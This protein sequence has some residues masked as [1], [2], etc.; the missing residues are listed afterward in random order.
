MTSPSIITHNADSRGA[1]NSHQDHLSPRSLISSGLWEHTLGACAGRGAYAGKDD[2]V[3]VRGI[4]LAE[5]DEDKRECVGQAPWFWGRWG[6]QNGQLSA[7][8]AA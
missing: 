6:G 4:E 8:R 3:D 7:G 5:K 2:G 1:R